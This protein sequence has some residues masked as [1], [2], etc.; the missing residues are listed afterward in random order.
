MGSQNWGNRHDLGGFCRD[1]GLTVSESAMMHA[2]RKPWNRIRCGHDFSV[3]TIEFPHAEHVHRL[4]AGNE[5]SFATKDLEREHRPY[6]S[7]HSQMVLLD[8]IVEVL[9]PAQFDIAAMSA[10]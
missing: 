3:T 4:N 8:D 10:L 5:D 9:A 7:F 6:D 2:V 1:K